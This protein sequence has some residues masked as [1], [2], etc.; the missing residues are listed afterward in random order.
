MSQHIHPTIPT[1]T[2]RCRTY[3]PRPVDTQK[4]VGRLFGASTDHPTVP[5]DSVNRVSGGCQSGVGRLKRVSDGFRTAVG[6]LSAGSRSVQTADRQPTDRMSYLL[7]CR[8]TGCR[9]AVGR[10]F[11][12]FC[13][14]RM[15]VC[16]LFRVLKL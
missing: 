14:C 5:S 11:G 13:T 6:R 9:T 1:T 15:G 8:P 12:T 16:R 2:N 3:T 10:L 7:V 4:N